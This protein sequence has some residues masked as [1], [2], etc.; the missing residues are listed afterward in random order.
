MF[1][2]QVVSK[3]VAD[4]GMTQ[5]QRN[6][7]RGQLAS[8]IEAFLSGGGRVTEVADNVRADPPRKPSMNYGSMPI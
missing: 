6:S 4:D 5:T 1:D 2:E 8:D 7:V 3:A